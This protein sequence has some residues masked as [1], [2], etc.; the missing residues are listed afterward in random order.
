M[1]VLSSATV[2]AAPGTVSVPGSP[3]PPQGMFNK[4]LARLDDRAL[5]GIVRSLP[6]AS[7]RRMAACELLVTR[8]QGLVTEMANDRPPRE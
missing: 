5:L 3:A 6:R 1:T 8:Y 4:D 2:C 7:E